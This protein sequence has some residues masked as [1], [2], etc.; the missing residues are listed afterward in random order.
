NP[1]N[2]VAWRA[3]YDEWGNLLGEENPEHLEQLI[4]LP[5]QQYDEE[6]GLHYNRHRY[7]SPGLGRYITQ[8]PIGLAGGWNLYQYPLNPIEKVDPLG[9][10]AWEDAKSGACYEG[11]CRL[12]SAFVGPDKFDSTDD[13]AFEALRKINGHSICQGVEYAGLVCK[14]KNNEYFYTPPQ[15]GNEDISYPFDSPCPS[16]TEIVAMYHT[17]GSDSN[18]V[19]K[20]E[21][22]SPTDKDL[23]KRKGI[24]NYLGTPKGSFQKVEPNGDQPINKS[25]LPSQCRIHTNGEIY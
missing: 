23:S 4:R 21:E 15:K 20:D 19:Y 1:D 16:G 8:D 14:N 24:P 5:G 25:S 13:A 12:F 10:S 11:V 22:F 7:Y 3:E 18:G 9:L 2:T 17:H 6:S